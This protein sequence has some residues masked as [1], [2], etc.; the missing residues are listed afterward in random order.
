M[1]RTAVNYENITPDEF[2]EIRE[3]DE[4]AVVIDC[5]T[6]AEVDMGHLDHDIHLDIMDPT[7]RQKV[8]E[9]DKTKS[10]LIYCRSGN[11][12]GSLCNYMASQGFGKLYN[13]AGGIISW[14]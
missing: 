12:S 13:L 2:K 14:N 11:R 5:R 1:F 7:I 8:E 9:L 4:N 10:Y 3:K 6:K